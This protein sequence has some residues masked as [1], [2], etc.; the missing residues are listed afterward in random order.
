[1][2]SSVNSCADHI[3]IAT[4]VFF[5]NSCTDHIII[6]TH[7]FF[8]EQLYNKLKPSVPGLQVVIIISLR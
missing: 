2:C 4:H 8:C 1:M 3:I 6:I 7:V 5:Q